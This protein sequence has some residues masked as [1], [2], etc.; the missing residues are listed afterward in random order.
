MGGSAVPK[1]SVL[2][3]ECKIRCL[4][5]RTVPDEKKPERSIVSLVD[6]VALTDSDGNNGTFNGSVTTSGLAEKDWTTASI[7]IVRVSPD[8]KIELP[9][10][11]FHTAGP[12]LLEGYSPIRWSSDSQKA[13][14][15]A[16]KFLS[17]KH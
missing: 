10:I 12:S 8:G 2:K 5:S 1:S 3:D 15:A 11:Y 16:L 9:A 6:S 13:L 17:G 7:S 4:C 14:D